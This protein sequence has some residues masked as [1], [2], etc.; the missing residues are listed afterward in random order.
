[1]CRARV[2]IRHGK[3]IHKDALEAFGLSGRLKKLRTEATELAHAIDRMEEGKG[4]FADVLHEYRD[5][6][7]VWQSV[8]ESDV[9]Y[10]VAMKNGW[11]EHEEE[12]EKKLR[13]AITET[14]SK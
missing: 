2:T 4:G 9:F 11:R 8:M 14:V 6:F 13:A 7:Y 3:M 12:S 1:L 10:D 5:C